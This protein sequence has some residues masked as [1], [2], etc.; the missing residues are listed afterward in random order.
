[1]VR[2]YSFAWKSKTIIT[3]HG[4][5]NISSHFFLIETTWNLQHHLVMLPWSSRYRVFKR[6]TASPD[7]TIFGHHPPPSLPN[8]GAPHLRGGTGSYFRQTA[9]FVASPFY[10]A[11]TA[12]D[13]AARYVPRPGYFCGRKKLPR[14]SLYSGGFVS[15]L[16]SPLCLMRLL[17]RLVGCRS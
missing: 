14:L 1:V 15:T 12:L 7:Q 4:N 5:S 13:I 9:L 3:P 10:Q 8:E 16:F 6:S 11:F 2:L 17:V